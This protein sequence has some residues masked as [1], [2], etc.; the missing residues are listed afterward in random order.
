MYFLSWK[1]ASVQCHLIIRKYSLVYIWL[2]K[3]NW[4]LFDSNWKK[5]LEVQCLHFSFVV[6]FEAPV[7][8]SL[9]RF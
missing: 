7:A 4:G 8:Q 2:I 1:I 6:L 3:M 5:M 9:E